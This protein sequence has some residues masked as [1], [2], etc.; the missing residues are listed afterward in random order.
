MVLDG[1]VRVLLAFLV[2]DLHEEAADEGL[3][4]VLVVRLVLESCRNEV[5]ASDVRDDCNIRSTN[6]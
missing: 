2:R 1:R 4:D 5:P 3:A 6:W